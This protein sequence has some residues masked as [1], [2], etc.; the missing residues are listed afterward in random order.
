MKLQWFSSPVKGLEATALMSE[1]NE[2][3]IRLTG[4]FLGITR[5]H[6][7]GDRKNS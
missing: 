3:P 5:I 1:G 4:I 7:I 2:R 6:Q